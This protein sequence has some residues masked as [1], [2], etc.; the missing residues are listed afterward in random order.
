M[1]NWLKL[2]LAPARIWVRSSELWLIVLAAFAGLLSG[3]AVALM[4]RIVQ[5]MHEAFFGIGHGSRL[6]E[7]VQLRSPLLILVPVAGGL[8]LGAVML[9]T[10]RWRRRPVVDPIEANALHGGRMSIADSF[11]VVVQNVISTYRFVRGETR[12][13]L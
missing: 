4:S 1:P 3:C 2:P 8:L 10:A 5:T 13:R 6:S 12:H 11:I 7:T 9:A